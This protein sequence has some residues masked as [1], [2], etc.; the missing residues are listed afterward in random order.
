MAFSVISNF[1][2]EPQ[3]AQEYA[4]AAFVENLQ[5]LARSL[6]VVRSFDVNNPAF[7]SSLNKGGQYIDLPYFP[8]IASLISRRDLS[9]T[10][11]P[12]DLDLT[13]AEDKAVILRRKAGPVKFTEDIF[14]RGVS[15]R[16]AE[17]EIGRQIGNAA[18]LDVRK[19]LLRVVTAALEE[20]DTPT[21]NCHISDIYSD[22]TKAN[23]T[24]ARLNLGRMLLKDAYDR[25][26]TIVMHSNV[27]YDL[28]GDN[29]A[30]YKIEN[31]GGATIV[32]GIPQAFGM[33]I[34]VVDDP[35]LRVAVTDEYFKYKTL[36]LGRDA[37]SLIY[38]RTLHISAERRLDFEA[39]YWRILA[40]YDYAP[41]LHGMAWNTATGPNPADA[42][43]E[44][45][46]NWLEA[47]TDHRD[48]LA[49]MIVH[50]SSVD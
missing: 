25:L 47:Y 20:V 40:N 45:P 13:G 21:A 49:A 11:A 10:S 31:V 37:L 29:I 30:N 27:F 46:A 1:V 15:V 22:T 50:N 28:V 26:T 17:D 8:D 3:L 44:T 24:Y 48:V 16:N 12:S 4:S 5:L 9:S 6:G 33:R 41:H 39:P 23:L 32:T 43:L 18:A 38:A 34:V 2:F 35:S 19:S 42:D 7:H 36:L 14:V